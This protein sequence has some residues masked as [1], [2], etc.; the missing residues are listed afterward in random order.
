MK[1]LILNTVRKLVPTT[2]RK[3]LRSW[4]KNVV[5]NHHLSRIASNP[6]QYLDGSNDSIR[7]MNRLIYGWGNP[8]WSAD[9]LYLMECGKQAQKAE[10][11]ILECG[12]GLTTVVMSLVKKEST[13]IIALE[14]HAD[15]AEKVRNQTNLLNGVNVDVVDCALKPYGDFDWYDIHHCL[16]KDIS[17][18]VCDGPPAST[19]GGRVGLLPL[20]HDYLK[21]LCVVLLD[22]FQRQQ[23]QDIVATWSKQSPLKY[24]VFGGAKK[25]ARILFE[26]K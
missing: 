11:L 26:S 10:D 4:N 23:E 21:P 9:A 15:W 24:E 25:F 18:V 8:D 20:V 5:L 1:Q 2:I 17:L 13:Q 7:L 14:H 22:D 3:R 12:S 19:L 16:L 6:N